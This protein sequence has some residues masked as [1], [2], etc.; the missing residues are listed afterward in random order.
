MPASRSVR[1][2]GGLIVAKSYNLAFGLAASGMIAYSL[3]LLVCARNPTKSAGG[4]T[5]T[6]KPGG[7]GHHGVLRF[8]RLCGGGFAGD[9][10]A[11]DDVD[12]AGGIYE[13]VLW[14]AGDPGIS[15]NLW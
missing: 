3:L 1:Q 6:R 11:I 2:F 5:D 7:D 13:Q 8:Y 10:C 12:T 9:D 4:G 15:R 14:R